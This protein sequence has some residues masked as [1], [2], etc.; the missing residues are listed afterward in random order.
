MSDC[1]QVRT[2]KRLPPGVVVL[3][4]RWMRVLVISVCWEG[5]KEAA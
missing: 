1:V 2:E 5:P 4:Y 3:I